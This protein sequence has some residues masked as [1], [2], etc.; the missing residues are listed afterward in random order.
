M[1]F[2]PDGPEIPIPLLRAHRAGD[3]LFVVGAGISKAARLPLFG[4]LADQIYA[5]L[6]QAIPGTPES[7][8]SRAEIEARDEGQY[9]RLIG[10]LEQRVVYRGADWRQPHNAVRDAVAD[11]LKPTN[12]TRLNAHADLLDLARGIDGQPRIVTTNFDTLFERAWRRRTRQ[13][14]LSSAGPAMPAVGSHDFAG[15]LHLHGRV[16]DRYNGLSRD[17]QFT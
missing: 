8:A 4:E 15:V 2:D 10:L 9:D 7:L 16:A 3:V 5:R 12:R 6:G 11:L 13:G 1:L 17:V 14:I